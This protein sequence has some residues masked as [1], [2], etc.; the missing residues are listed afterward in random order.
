MIEAAETIGH[1]VS[2]ALG[3]A[4][5]AGL[6]GVEIIGQIASL[7]GGGVAE[8]APTPEKILGQKEKAEEQKIDV[9]RFR[10]DAEYRRQIMAAS[11]PVDE[12][13]HNSLRWF[14]KIG[15]ALA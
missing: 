5:K 3:A 8:V 15:L 13:V 11:R 4:V 10:T 6:G 9:A 14:G 7:F 1:G 2:G 12:T